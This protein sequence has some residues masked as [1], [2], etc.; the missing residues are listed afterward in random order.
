LGALIDDAAGSAVPLTELL[1]KVRVLA[2]RAKAPELDAWA[3][4]E[5]E[6]YG[7]REALPRYRGPLAAAVFG[8]F[9]GYAGSYQRRV[10]LAPS[11]L[12][13]D[14]RHESLFQIFVVQSVSEIENVIKEVEAAG[15]TEVNVGWSQENVVILNQLIESGKLTLLPMHYIEKIYATLPLWTLSGVLDTV[16]TRLLELLMELETMSPEPSSGH[17]PALPPPSTVQNLFHTVVYDGGTAAVGVNAQTIVNAATALPD[18]IAEAMTAAANGEKSGFLKE[19]AKW[20]L[21]VGREIV[22]DVG[23]KALNQQL[24]LPPG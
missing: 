12:P 24:G 15:L 22:V 19:A 18:H 2:H 4:Q 21:G 23:A 17:E 20:V 3:K 13:E 8:D 9:T 7:D 1:R 14:L 6:G 5:L 10:P 16:R 11:H